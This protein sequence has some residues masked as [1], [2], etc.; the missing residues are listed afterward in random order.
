M[1]SAVPAAIS[2]P[3]SDSLVRVVEVSPAQAKFETDSVPGVEL[4]S[5]SRSVWL[6]LDTR[7]SARAEADE[8]VWLNHQVNATY[9]S[10]DES[11]TR[12]S[13]ESLPL[14][15]RL[16]VGAQDEGTFW[17]RADTLGEGSMGT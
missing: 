17:S 8:A 10:G 3:L 14:R 7:S 5:A 16:G 13:V 12:L 15:M 11:E 4:A 6:H 9:Q 1:V 2:N